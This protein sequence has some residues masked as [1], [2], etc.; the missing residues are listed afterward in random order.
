MRRE[1][2]N[3]IQDTGNRHYVQSSV[4]RIGIS[5]NGRGEPEILAGT[6]HVRT[7]SEEPAGRAGIRFL[8]RTSVCHG[9]AA[10]RAHPR[11]HDQGRHSA[12]SDHV[13]QIRRAHVRLGLPRSAGGKRDGETA[14]AGNGPR[15]FRQTGNR[16]VRDRQFQRSMP[17]NRAALYVG[18]EIHC[19]P[20]GP[21]GRFRAR[22]PHDGPGLHGVDLVGVQTAVGQGSD[23]RGLPRA[24]V[25]PPLRHAA[26]EF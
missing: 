14:C 22:L 7:V 2:K 19:V 15:E 18:M 23:L 4:R 25:L 17:R 6:R 13:R 8:R 1:W 16:E 20:H 9:P 21:L 26:G 3:N 11:G 10:L 12:L 24:A 5:E